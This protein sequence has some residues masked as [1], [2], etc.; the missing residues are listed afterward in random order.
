M[1]SMRVKFSS[2]VAF[3]PC[4]VLGS[5]ATACL[6]AGEIPHDRA[7]NRSVARLLTAEPYTWSTVAMGGGGY[8]TGLLAHPT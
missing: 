1:S 4:L 3:A 7:L 2:L 5:L 6:D 8:V